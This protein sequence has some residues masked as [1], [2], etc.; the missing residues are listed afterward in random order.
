MTIG[1][2]YRHGVNAD[3]ESMRCLAVKLAKDN[4]IE[5]LG[6]TSYDWRQDVTD[7]GLALAKEV[8]SEAGSHDVLLVGHSQGGLV[9]RVAA[10]ALTGKLRA[11]MAGG[12]VANRIA[13]CQKKHLKGWHCR[14]LGV[15]M[16][17]T[18]NAGALTFGQQS[19]AVEW[20]LQFTRRFIPEIDISE[21]SGLH[22]LKDITTPRLFER[23]QNWEV[24]AKYLSIS[25]TRVSR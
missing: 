6:N 2:F 23:L 15:V 16:I 19:V 21:I 18:P 7:S 17:A 13:E 5:N 9:C 25:G 24:D 10:V 14:K 1:A 20:T 4:R 8:V 11:G 12:K 22:N 3:R